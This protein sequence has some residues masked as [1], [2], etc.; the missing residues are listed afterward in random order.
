MMV[1]SKVRSIAV[2]VM[3]PGGPGILLSGLTATNLAGTL[4]EHNLAFFTR[5]DAYT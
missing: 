2:N 1:A 5:S 3:Y 4:E